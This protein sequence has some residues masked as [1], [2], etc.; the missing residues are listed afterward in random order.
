MS[1][2]NDVKTYLD[3]PIF[4][5]SA[6]FQANPRK[7]KVDLVVGVYRSTDLKTYLMNTIK[8]AEFI[9]WENEADKGYTP[10]RGI[11][12][13]IT[14]AMKITFGK[15]LSEKERERI[16]GTQTVGAT[17][18]LRIGGDFIRSEIGNKISLANPTWANHSTIFQAC[19][20]KI[21]RYPYYNNE[22]HQLEFEKVF[23][24]INK[25]K[26]RDA[27]LM[28][29]SSHNP[30][31][32]DF[33]KEQWKEL[34]QLILRKQVLPFFDF[35]YQGFSVGIEEDAWPIRYF[36]REGHELLIAN[37]FAK[38]FGIYAERAGVLFVLSQDPKNRRKI[39]AAL[40]NIIRGNYSGPPKHGAAL[41]AMILANPV[42]KAKWEEE[43]NMMRG[44]I[45]E[46]R[47]L[48]TDKLLAKAKKRNFQYLKGRNGFFCICG[49]SPD[50]ADRLIREYG[51]YT[52]RSGRI[53]IAG[54]NGSNVDHVV[55]SLLAVIEGE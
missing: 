45:Q 1:L 49:I 35:A 33:K 42:L 9:L 31:G 23:D 11:P 32:L 25:L 52:T 8:E 54:L 20:L 50:Q 27:V 15:E 14:E 29:V 17:G 18:A 47:R 40:A 28:Q 10:I 51:I 13:F 48:F 38:S 41:V 53:N 34:S 6:D 39:E 55:D 16:V 44:R 21:E 37:T 30:T 7:D 3:D 24:Y 26:P 5:L 2:F 46:M 12:E 36:L 43:V 19:G 22:T 4:G